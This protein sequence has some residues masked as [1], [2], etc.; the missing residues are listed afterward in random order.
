MKKPI[1]FYSADNLR[2]AKVDGH[3]VKLQ[4]RYAD[5]PGHNWISAWPVF[6]WTVSD[7]YRAANA[8]NNEK[9]VYTPYP[10]VLVAWVRKLWR[11]A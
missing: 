2:R 1:T 10:P 8:W 6:C 9:R 5:K 7:T 3:W 4:F 11:I